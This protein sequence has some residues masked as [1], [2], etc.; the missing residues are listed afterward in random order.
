MLIKGDPRSLD[1]S[2]CVQSCVEEILQVLCSRTRGAFFGV[3]VFGLNPS[4]GLGV[5][6]LVAK[7]TIEYCLGFSS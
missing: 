2:S 1:Y 4:P 3:H 5:P 6:K 7:G